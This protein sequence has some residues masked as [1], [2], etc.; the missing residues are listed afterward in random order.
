MSPAVVESGRPRRPGD[1]GADWVAAIAVRLDRWIAALRELLVL[2]RA[3]NIAQKR[4]ICE[5]SAVMTSEGTPKSTPRLCRYP[6]KCT[7]LGGAS[8]SAGRA[9][10]VSSATRSELSPVKRVRAGEHATAPGLR[11]ARGS[12][13]RAADGIGRQWT[14]DETGLTEQARSAPSPLGCSVTFKGGY[15]HRNR[16]SQ[17]PH[18]RWQTGPAPLFW[19]FA[20]SAGN[21][22]NIREHC[23]NLLF[24]ID[25]LLPFLFPISRPRPERTGTAWRSDPY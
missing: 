19:G 2:R 3:S 22:G 8:D 11:A 17:D 9:T 6:L 7:G 18:P 12:S 4:P 1:G 23:S 15:L 5:V 25:Y 20:E 10:P 21:Y 14:P 24:C 16:A 13:F